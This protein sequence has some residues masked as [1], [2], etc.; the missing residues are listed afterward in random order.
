M[1]KYIIITLA[2]LCLS[3]GAQTVTNKVPSGKSEVGSI[4]LTLGGGGTHIDG[5]NSFGLDVSVSTNPLESLPNLWFGIAQ[6]VYWEPTFAGSTDITVDWNWHVYKQLYLNTGWSGGALYDTAWNPAW[7]TGPEATFE[8]YLG[9]GGAFLY[10][11]VNYDINLTG[12][13]K[14]G[15]RYSFGIGIAF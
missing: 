14:D 12:E 4:E 15:F 7:R 2:A 8:Y 3:V 10:S 1:K 13:A 6:G 5:H 9:D 11:G